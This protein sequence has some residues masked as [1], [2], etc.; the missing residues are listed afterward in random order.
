MSN[1]CGMFTLEVYITFSINVTN[2]PTCKEIIQKT[3]AGKAEVT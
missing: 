2:I 1:S 3:E